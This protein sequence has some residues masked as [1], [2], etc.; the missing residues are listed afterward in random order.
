VSQALYE[1]NGGRP[2]D[3][4]LEMWAKSVFLGATLGEIINLQQ[5]GQ[6]QR[7][8]QMKTAMWTRFGYDAGYIRQMAD[9]EFWDR[10]YEKI[11]EIDPLI[12]EVRGPLLSL[13]FG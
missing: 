2:N 13:P 10:E 12:E 11:R 9:Q 4:Q 1:R 3:E 8:Q 6:H 5:P 7:L